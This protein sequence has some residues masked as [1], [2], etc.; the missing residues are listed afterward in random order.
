MNNNIKKSEK[1]INTVL[2]KN[3]DLKVKEKP[4]NIYTIVADG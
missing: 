1:N 4:I 2:I 3:V